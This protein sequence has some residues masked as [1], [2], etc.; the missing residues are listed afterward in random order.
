M[1]GGGRILRGLLAVAQPNHEVGGEA[2]TPWGGV[3]TEWREHLVTRLAWGRRGWRRAVMPVAAPR[4]HGNAVNRTEA[5]WL[6]AR[7]SR[8]DR[9]AGQV[10]VLLRDFQFTYL[11]G[12]WEC[13]SGVQR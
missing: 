2:R 4:A 13:R 1:T 7:G 11:V 9:E 5:G 10:A 12:S 6:G 8:G 3:F